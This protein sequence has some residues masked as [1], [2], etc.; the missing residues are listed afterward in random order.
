MTVTTTLAERMF[1]DKRATVI[2]L[3]REGKAV[4]RLLVG[5]G[6]TVTV[7]DLKDAEDLRATL[8]EMADLP[9]SFCLG[10]HQ[11]GVLEADIIF[12]SPGVPLDAP[13]MVEARRRGLVLS[14]EPRLF[15]HLCPADI[16][17]ITGSSGKT[18]TITLVAR[19]LE[20][21]GTRVHVGGNIGSPLI[22]KLSQ[23]RRGDVVVMELSS[24]Q[25][26][27]FGSVLDAEPRGDLVAPLFPEGAWSPPI[28][29]V[30]NVTP[31]HLDRHPT[32]DAYVEA[33]SRIWRYQHGEDDTVL[34]WDDPVTRGF[35]RRCPGHVTFFSTREKVSRGAYLQGDSLLLRRGNGEDT[36]CSVDNVRLRGMHN[37]ANLLAAC[38]VA[39]LLGVLPKE[40]AEVA[41][42][43][44]GVE[45]RLEPVRQYDGVWYYNDS[46]A[47]SPERAIAALKSFTEP[48]V[49]LAGGR[50][51]HLPWEDWGELVERT[52]VQLIVF[53]EA[54]QLIES[55]LDRLGLRS[56]PV[57]R[58]EGLGHAVKLAHSLAPPGS[59]VLFS[60]GGTSFDAY[61]D[62]AERGD[63]FKRSVEN[64]GQ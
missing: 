40:M 8:A 12:V 9:L 51:K 29:A 41:A 54:A 26:D 13:I 62:Y 50:D 37:V 2:G 56:P 25:L 33:K 1:R 3:G 47:T 14:S 10:G 60:P 31:N 6:A 57:H 52:V 30:L 16:I 61:R 21:H 53:G 11:P 64:L 55:V 24:F 48:I 32:M 5:Q 34:S 59:V 27:Y 35:A 22:G 45:H 38:T 44:A 28:A 42:T 17:G 58:A 15:C 19:M 20:M 49:L 36:I 23:I 43:F 63:D 39:D 18:T 4:A 46:I 7:T